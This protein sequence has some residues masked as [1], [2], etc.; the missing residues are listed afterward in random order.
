MQTLPPMQTYE[1]VLHN[2][3]VRQRVRA[4]EHHRRYSD[5]WGDSHYIEIKAD[6]E[7]GALARVRQKY[8][9][10]DGFV[11]EGVMPR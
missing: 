3:H 4:G 9:E 1:I 5:E 11:I 7:A 2:E 8:P 10:E 6:D